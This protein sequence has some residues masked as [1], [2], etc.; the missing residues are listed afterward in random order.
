[1]KL[2]SSKPKKITDKIIGKIKEY[3]D[4]HKRETL[5]EIYRLESENL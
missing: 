3:K 2:K 1:M 4:S 5:D